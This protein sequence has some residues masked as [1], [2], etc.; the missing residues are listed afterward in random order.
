MISLKS[1]SSKKE[2]FSI[3]F[4]SF[5][6]N[7]I[8]EMLILSSWSEQFRSDIGFNGVSQ[9]W[10]DRLAWYFWLADSPGV[11]QLE[12]MNTEEDM[13]IRGDRCTAVFQVK[14][15][16][17]QESPE[18]QSFSFLERKLV[19]SNLFDDTNTPAFEHQGDIPPDLFTVATVEITMDLEGNATII[20]FES[21]DYLRIRYVQEAHQSYPIINLERSF[22]CQEIDRDVPGF[23]MGYP[24]FDCL[25][26]LYANTFKQPPLEIRC[27]KSPGYEAI[28]KGGDVYAREINNIKGFKLSMF[29][30]VKGLSSYPDM[31]CTLENSDEGSEDIIYDRSFACGNFHENK[32]DKKLPVMLNRKWWSLAHTH[33]ES[34]LTSSCGCH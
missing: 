2:G 21:M 30:S 24:L 13:D 9:I 27:S 14:C 19:Q 25:M 33:Y 20:S 28:V 6:R 17:Y 4:E 12:M 22:N 1:F 15:Y 16:P 18:F 32:G 29:Y 7:K 31:D 23:Q 8:E 11:Y 34:E 5:F 26:C 10:G 3:E